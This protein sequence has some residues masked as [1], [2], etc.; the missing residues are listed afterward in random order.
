LTLEKQM[1]SDRETTTHETV[2]DVTEER[3]ARVYASAFMAVAAKSKDAT[4][5]VDEVG[6]LVN[7]VLSRFPRLEDTLR[8]AL[9]SSE[10]KE[11]SLD[12]ILSGRASAPVL[13]FLKVL[14]RHDRLAV[15]RPIAGILKKLD[16]E[17]RGLTDVEVR[18]A[19]PIDAT[20]QNEIQSRLRKAL[21]GE[22][23][24]HVQIDPSLLAGMVIRVGDRVYDGSVHTQ[25]ENARRAMID[26]ITETI[27]TSPERFMAPTS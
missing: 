24:L 26:R 15:L 18:V 22:P 4:A 25:L 16:A 7:D 27:E 8:S 2:M 3:I 5:L 23:V 10:E 13:N 6:S 1:P 17:R 21:G 11:Q 14:A 20:L 9:V 12:R 19:A